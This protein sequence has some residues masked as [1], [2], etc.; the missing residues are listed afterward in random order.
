[1]RKYSNNKLPKHIKDKCTDKKL[2]QKR[3]NGSDR[4]SIVHEV[5]I[6]KSW[7]VQHLQLES[8]QHDPSR[9]FE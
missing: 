8:V 2:Q 1:M 4:D 3:H 6:H 9:N 7:D 5:V